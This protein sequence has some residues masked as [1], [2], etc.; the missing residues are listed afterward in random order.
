M[1]IIISVTRRP[2]AKFASA[3]NP[4]GLERVKL[5]DDPNIFV[6]H[7]LFLFLCRWHLLGA[8]DSF[9]GLLVRHQVLASPLERVGLELSPLVRFFHPQ[10][11]VKFCHYD[12]EAD[13]L[14]QEL[15]EAVVDLGFQ[16]FCVFRPVNTV[17][18]HRRLGVI[19]VLNGPTLAQQAPEG[20]IAP[21]GSRAGEE[22][23]VRGRQR[24]RCFCVHEAEVEV[25]LCYGLHC[26]L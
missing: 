1:N 3:Q 23:P 22:V 16:E 20:S 11:V 9:E 17:H 4:G 8:N 15:E 2:R 7:N 6:D 5:S 21:V 12:L 24:Q 18:L 10:Q 14:V 26:N 13:P 25:V 19:L